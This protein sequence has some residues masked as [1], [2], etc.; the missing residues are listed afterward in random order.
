[1]GFQPEDFDHC[2]CQNYDDGASIPAHA[3]DEAC[4]DKDVKVLTLN[5]VGSAKFSLVCKEGQVRFG[6]GPKEYFL[7][8]A[9]CQCTHKHAVQATSSG[10]ISLTFRNSKNLKSAVSPIAS[11][12]S[13]PTVIA[14]HSSVSPRVAR[15][16]SKRTSPSGITYFKDGRDVACTLNETARELLPLSMER[17]MNVDADTRPKFSIPLLQ[18]FV[19]DGVRRN[20]I[21]SFGK[22]FFVLNDSRMICV[23]DKT[24][25]YMCSIPQGIW[26]WGLRAGKN[27][28]CWMK[29]VDDKLVF[30]AEKLQYPTLHD[31]LNKEPTGRLVGHGNVSFYDDF[32]RGTTL[33]RRGYCWVNPIL[34]SGLTISELPNLSHVP[35]SFV[36]AHIKDA[37]FVVRG[38]YLHFDKMGKTSVGTASTPVGAAEVELSFGL[39]KIDSLGSDQVLNRVLD[40]IASRPAFKEG[41]SVMVTLDNILSNYIN[42]SLKLKQ[43]THIGLNQFLTDEERD[44]LANI[45]GGVHMEFKQQWRR[46]HSFLNSMR[47]ILNHLKQKEQHSV[48][49][50]AR[51]RNVE[52]H[53]ANRKPE[54]KTNGPPKEKHKTQKYAKT[55]HN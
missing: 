46:S 15:S 18:R 30:L 52:R 42:N 2:L 43:S 14:S 48:K 54:E 49:I 50:T 47:A 53:L 32:Y 16:P 31:I 22:K 37:K 24:T 35:K 25:Q 7:M 45:F 1:M 19:D 10:R 13:S 5:A 29:R 4:Y 8:P 12:V 55:A 9:G 36:L 11:V 44:M 20:S 51:A 40:T 38:K 39:S 17:K 21:G 33:G 6:L 3:D 23:V 41:S 28:Y 26:F 27:N 34:D